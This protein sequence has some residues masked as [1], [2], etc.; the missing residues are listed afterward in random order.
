M[1]SVLS[2]YQDDSF[3]SVYQPISSHEEDENNTESEGNKSVRKTPPYPEPYEDDSVQVQIVP[4]SN[5]LAKSSFLSQLLLDVVG[6]PLSV[7]TS[8]EERLREDFSITQLSKSKAKIEE[9]IKK[10]PYDCKVSMICDYH[11]IN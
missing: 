7:L 6:D 10:N 1:L 8:T 5:S 11:V 9:F 3:S 4:S 2:I